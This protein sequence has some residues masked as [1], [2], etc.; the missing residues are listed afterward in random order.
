[1][2]NFACRSGC[3]AALLVVAIARYDS[4]SRLASPPATTAKLHKLFLRGA[5]VQRL[6]LTSS[7]P[8]LDSLTYFSEPYGDT[9]FDRQIKL[10]SLV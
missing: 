9:Y 10:L 4:S 8:L 2:H 5:Y 7:H 6:T 1:M 3:A